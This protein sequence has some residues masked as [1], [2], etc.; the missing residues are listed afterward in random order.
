[1]GEGPEDRAEQKLNPKPV[2]SAGV[3]GI[4]QLGWDFL[5][6]ASA[7]ASAARGACTQRLPGAPG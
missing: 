4:R 3:G 6:I 2:K 1:M 7:T 5:L